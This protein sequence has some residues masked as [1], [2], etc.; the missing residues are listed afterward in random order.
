MGLLQ[1]GVPVARMELLDELAIDAVNRYSKLELPVLPT[2]FMEFSGSPN[3]VE[4]Q[5]TVASE[6]CPCIHTQPQSLVLKL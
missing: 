2:L 4:E 6:Y 5:A 1:S 3:S